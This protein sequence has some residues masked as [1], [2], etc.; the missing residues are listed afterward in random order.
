VRV[1][2]DISVVGFDDM[3]VARDVWPALT[4]IRLP[5]VEMGERAMTLAL[6]DHDNTTVEMAPAS[7]VWRDSCA[8]PR[9]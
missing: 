2:E 7:L 6:E 5:L 4:T 1:P 8:A 3:P 9:S